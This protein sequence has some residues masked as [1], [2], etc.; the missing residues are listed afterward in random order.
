[1]EENKKNGNKN[2]VV[3]GCIIIGFGV[4]M[5]FRSQIIGSS[6]L[7]GVGLIVIGWTNYR[8]K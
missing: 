6:I 2:G 7:F 4:A 8:N 1:M 3:V 5:L